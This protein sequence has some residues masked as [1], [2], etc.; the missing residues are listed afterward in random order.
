MGK[1]IIKILDPVHCKANKEARKLILK[2]LAYKKSNWKLDRKIGRRIESVDTQHFITGRDG[3][4]GHF[5]TGLL[6][7]VLKN[8]EDKIK[9]IGDLEHLVPTAKPKLKGIKFRPDQIKALEVINKKQR[10]KIV[11]PTGTGK[12]LIAAGIISMFTK[13]RILFLCHTIDLLNQTKEEFEKFFKDIFILGGKH[14]SSFKAK[15]M[16]KAKNPILIST[17][18]SYYKIHEKYNCFFDIVIV[19]EVHHVHTLDS[20][21]GKV[22]EMNCAPRR[23]GLTATEPKKQFE[24]LVNEGLFGPIIASLGLNE[25]INLG[26]IAKP[27]IQLIPVPYN[28]KTNLKLKGSFA[29][30]YTYGIVKNRERNKLIVREAIVSLSMGNIFLIVVEKLEH[31]EKLQKMLKFKGVKIPFIRGATDSEDRSATRDRMKKKL[32]KGAICTRVWKEGI[33]IPA[34]N[35]VINAHGMKDEKTVYQILG[36]GIRTHE[37]KTELLLTDFLDPYRIL[38]EHSIARISVYIKE[39]WI[40]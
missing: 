20:Q 29:N 39:G 7:R 24:T 28:P 33:N 3:S 31:G 10:G 37:D 18:Q 38:A 23:Y 1:A 5:L 17:I 40:K 13:H 4:G 15:K 2:S 6:P 12:T 8:K 11:F 27:K 9:V 36:R 34:L 22:L 26:I 32:R 35:H 19:D 21:Y 14:T 30:C 16:K 25:G